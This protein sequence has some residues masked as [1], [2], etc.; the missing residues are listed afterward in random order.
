MTPY[1]PQRANTQN[2]LVYDWEVFMGPGGH[3]QWRPIPLAGSN[4]TLPDIIMLTTE[5]QE[6]KKQEGR[7]QSAGRGQRESQGR[8]RFEHPASVGEDGMRPDP[9]RLLGV[10][11]QGLHCASLVA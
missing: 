10:Y 9:W 6:G 7:G 3:H 1:N 8:G 2:L 4:E 11:R 5:S